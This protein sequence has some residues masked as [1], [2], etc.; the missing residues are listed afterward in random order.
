MY[1]QKKTWDVVDIVRQLKAIHFEA[2][3]PYNDGWVAGGCKQDLYQL[4]CII[5]DLYNTCP[6]FMGEDKWE[7]KRLIEILKR[8]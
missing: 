8:D 1:M 6:T 2:N 5:E 4:K 7:Q 3:N